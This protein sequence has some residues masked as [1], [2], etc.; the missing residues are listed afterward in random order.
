MRACRSTSI[1]IFREIYFDLG[2]RPIVFNGY[3]ENEIYHTNMM[4]A[5]GESYAYICLESIRKVDG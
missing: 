2:Y 5:I 1:T 4:M 3:D